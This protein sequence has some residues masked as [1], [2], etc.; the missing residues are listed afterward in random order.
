MNLLIQNRRT[1]IN[2]SA[3]S[4]TTIAALALLSPRTTSP[5]HKAAMST[6]SSSPPNYPTRTYTPRHTTWPYTRADMTPEDTTTDTNFYSTPRFVTHIDDH[7]IETLAQYYATA[8]PRT[9]RILDLCSSWISHFPASLDEAAAN[10]DLEVAGVGMSVPELK[11]NK[12]LQGKW[13]VHDLNASPD[14]PDMKGLF[15]GKFANNRKVV[16]SEAEEDVSESLDGTCCVVSIDYL[17][18]PV[19]VLESTLK[20]TK[21]GGSVHLI[22]S[23]RCFPTK[24]VTRWLSID[25]EERLEMVGDYLWFAGWRNIEILTLSDGKLKEEAEQAQ[26]GGMSAF[27]KM[28]GMGGGRC[29]PLWVVRAKKE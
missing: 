17:T 18:S 9:G 7:A 6:S 28:L 2:L 24:A 19:K 5:I 23:N 20:N 22:I 25:E 14:L 4:A 27:M 26:Q 3:L 15:R 29:D 13:A 21:A 16:A 1:L 10:G 8:L 12:L 11:A